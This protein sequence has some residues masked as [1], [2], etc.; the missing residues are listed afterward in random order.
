MT[1]LSLSRA[2]ARLIHSLHRRKAR[3]AQGFFLA[4]GLRVVEELVASRLT[5]RLAVVSSEL[6]D[7]PRGQALLER[8][9]Q[10][11]EIR[12]VPEHVLRDV[13][14]TENPQGI[15]V[16]AHEPEDKLTSIQP[17][18]SSNLLVCD[19]IQ[20]PGNLGTLIRVADAFALDAVLLLPGT[21]DPWNAK[22]VRSAAGSSF[23][24]PLVSTE[25]PESLEWL[26]ARSFR[27]L[28]AETSG[29]PLAVNSLP[30]RIALVVGNEGAGLRADVRASVDQLVRVEMP[31]PAESLNVAV[32]AGILLYA[33]TS[34]RP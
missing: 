18:T 3:E 6:E 12:V 14:A 8:L 19:G 23:R 5:I 9:T 15:V 28:G 16:I 20:D 22:V 7:N 29:Q 27:T 24:V 13:A 17:Q 1:A 11:T 26:R 4:E 33:L 21:V 31:G 32:A 10:R 34:R 2:E 30:A 25:W